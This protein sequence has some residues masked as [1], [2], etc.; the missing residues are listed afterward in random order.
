VGG[1]GGQEH[2]PV[3]SR[4]PCGRPGCHNTALYHVRGTSGTWYVCDNDLG[5]AQKL[6]GTPRTTEP[7]TAQDDGQETLFDIP[8]VVKRAGLL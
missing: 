3:V 6:A 2:E 4:P 1:A 8:P 7:V 5:W